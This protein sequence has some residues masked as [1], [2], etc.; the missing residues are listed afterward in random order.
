[1]SNQAVCSTNS[2]QNY[3]INQNS[4]TTQKGKYRVLSPSKF[5][6]VF[7]LCKTSNLSK[8]QTFFLLTRS[9]SV[10]FVCWGGKIPNVPTPFIFGDTWSWS[11]EDASASS[12][13]SFRVKLSAEENST[14]LVTMRSARLAPSESSLTCF[15]FSLS[16]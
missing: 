14:T 1:M 16:V 2:K 5:F 3:L 8:V 9:P 12:F 15:S 4:N 6:G 11:R 10:S 13:F 7:A